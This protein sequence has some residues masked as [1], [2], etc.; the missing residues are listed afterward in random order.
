[1][2]A[3]L[4]GCLLRLA[5]R[6]EILWQTCSGCWAL[7]FITLYSVVVK[8]GGIEEVRRWIRGL[9]SD[10]R[11]EAK[12]RISS[13]LDSIM[14][15]DHDSGCN[16]FLGGLDQWRDCENTI[17]KR[18][19]AIDRTP[20]RGVIGLGMFVAAVVARMV[21]PEHSLL[22]V[23]LAICSL[24]VFGWVLVGVAPLLVSAYH[25]G[26]TAKVSSAVQDVTTSGPSKP[27]LSKPVEAF[28]QNN[29]AEEIRRVKARWDDEHTVYA[30]KPLLKEAR[31]KLKIAVSNTPE[32]GMY[33]DLI[34]KSQELDRMPTTTDDEW[35]VFRSAAQKF[36]IDVSERVGS[37]VGIKSKAIHA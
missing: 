4:S 3:Y 20:S 8:M 22:S 18:I 17:R 12:S 28:S 27:S 23:S 16:L 31:L 24:V 7:I 9:E 36:F 29:L 21:E 35:T 19:D 15:N 5:A 10:K 14:K 11:D 2:T 30:L 13:G 1:M 33:D 34:Q 25:H 32:A 26:F 37:G 6:W